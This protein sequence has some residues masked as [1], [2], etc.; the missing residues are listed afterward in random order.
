M[1]I[2]VAGVPRCGT[3]LMARA[4]E[5][6]PLGSTWPGNDKAEKVFKTHEHFSPELF[7]RAEANRAIFMYG[8][9]GRA[10]T[11]FVNNRLDAQSLRNLGLANS[12]TRQDIL[13]ADCLGYKAMLESWLYCSP[14]SCAVPVVILWVRYERLFEAL[15]WIEEWLRQPIKMEW[16]GRDTIRADPKFNASGWRETILKEKEGV[17]FGVCISSLGIPFR[18]GLGGLIHPNW[19]IKSL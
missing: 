7:K 5:G 3:T 16:R 11:S 9:I 10:V 12:L 14:D 19:L 17:D 18:E 1:K 15:P 8:D 4:L 2:I 13:D 6:L